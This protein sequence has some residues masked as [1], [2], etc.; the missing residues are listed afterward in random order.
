MPEPRSTLDEIVA[1]VLDVPAAELTDDA[2][3]ATYS[4]WTSLKHLL[5]ISALEDRYDLSFSRD[6][7]R[8]IRTLGDLRRTLAGKEAGR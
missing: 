5:V 1:R 4:E 2:G 7:I 3:P 6:E 8:S